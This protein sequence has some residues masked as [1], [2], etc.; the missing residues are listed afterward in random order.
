MYN[1]ILVRYGELST[2]GKNRKYFIEQLQNN[3][4]KVLTDFKGIKLKAQRDHLYI[5]LNGHDYQSVGDR[6]KYIFGIQSYSPVIKIQKDISLLEKTAVMMMKEVYQDGQTFKVSTKRA[7]HN[8]KLKT[9]DINQLL[10]SKIFEEFDYA[11]VSM[12]NP[13]VLLRVEVRMDYIYLTNQIIQCAGGLPVGT[14][15]KGMLMLSGGI[16]S[17]VAGYLAM[18][19]GI[20]VEAVHFSSPPYTSPKSLAKTKELAGKIAKY[21]GS[22]NFIEVPFTKIQETIKNNVPEGY[23]MTITRRMMLR[24]CDLICQKRNGLAIVNG[25]SLGQ[26]ASQ[27]MESMY[28]INEV[29]SRPI[30]RPVVTMDKTEIIKIAEEIDTFEIAI[31]P[32]EDCCTIFA[33]KSPKTKPKLDKVY[34]YEKR[35]DIDGLLEESLAN[36]KIEKIKPDS[37]FLIENS[38]DISN[39]L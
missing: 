13:D 33:P 23:W 29:T 24:L 18:K 28:A 25:E 12:K 36:L 1:E 20:K 38:E 34:E 5:E 10:G 26:V 15:G 37:K 22:I 39:L 17:P 7:D 16:D 3:V 11:K 30:I 2:K 35:L 4:Q 19:R 6:L 31:Q 9:N 27:T 21:S 14:S 32:F 8:F